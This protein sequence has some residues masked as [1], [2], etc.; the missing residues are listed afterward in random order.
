MKRLS[1]PSAPILFGLL[2]LACASA[3]G[4]IWISEILFNPPGSDAPNE[5]IELR[6][7]PNLVL[8]A[9]TYFV[10]V[11]GDTAKNPGTIKNVFDL[12]GRSIGGNGFLVLLQ[13]NSLYL[14]NSNATLLTNSGSG[15]GWGSGSGSSI[16]HKGDGGIT[17]L[18]HASVT[19]FLLQ[20]TN[21][22]VPGN[23]IDA[24]NDGVPDGAQFASWTIL[25]SVG[26]LGI[27]GAGDFAYGQINFR[28][29]PAAGATNTVP[30]TF[31]PGYVARSG[32]TTNWTAADWV[33]SD[34]TGTAPNFALGLASTQPSNLG[35]VGLTNIGAPNFGAPAIPGLVAGSS[36]G[37]TDVSESGATDTY[38]VLLNTMPT[39]N[40]T[41]QI[42]AD[43]QLQIST[44]AGASFSSSAM[45]TFANTTPRQVTVRALDDTTVDTSPHPAFIHHIITSSAD[46]AHY[47]VTAPPATLRVNIAEND[48]ALLNELKVNPPG[49]TDSPFEYMEIQGLPGALLTNVFFLAI[50]GNQE[51]NPGNV[52]LA[53]DL[54]GAHFGS[55]G[56]LV[57][58]ATNSPYTLPAGAGVFTDARFNAPG[59]AL[60]NGAVSFLLVSSPVPFKEGKDLDSGN[61]G[62]L[63]GLPDGATIL[64]AVG[65]SKGGSNDVVYG[66]AVL[67]LALPTPDAASRFPGNTSPRSAAAWFYGDL[68]GTN[69]ATLLYDSTQVSTN[70][71]FGALLTPGAVN[72]ITIG[73]SSITPFSG[74]IG[75]P[76]N[77]GAT[78]TVFDSSIYSN[79]LVVT[80]SSSNPSVVPDANLSVTTIGPGGLRLLTVNPVG[81]GYAAIIITANDGHNLAQLAFPYAASEMGRPG[82][83]FHTWASDGSTALAVDPDNMFVGD[84]ENQTLRLY[85]RHFS[86]PPLSEFDFAFEL[87][88]TGQEAGEVDI[89]ASTRVGNRLF[90]MG[91]QS[92]NNAGSGRTN[93]SRIFA[94]DLSPA[95]PASTLSYVGRYDHIKED[96]LNW[97]ANNL[98]GKGSNYYGFV[99]SAADG[100][101]PKA[102]DGFNIEG[103]TMAP[104]SSNIAWIGFRA[105]LVPPSE[106]A[107][108]LIVTVTNFD[109]LAIGDAPAG[110]ARF[111]PPIELNL[112]CRGIRSIESTSNAVLISAGPPGKATGASPDFRL[113]TWTGNPADLPQER[114]A[115]LTGLTPEGLVEVPPTPWNASSQVQ[116]ISDNGTTIYYGDDI[117]A[118]HLPYPGFKKF[119]S[120]FVALGDIAVSRPACARFIISDSTAFLSWC[121]VPLLTYRVQCKT[122]LQDI[123]WA[124]V[125]GLVTANGA[126]T[127]KPLP[128]EPGPQRFYRVIIPP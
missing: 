96:L 4:E 3:R 26:V 8:P 49:P 61:N 19:F 44:N 21:V 25:D 97:D 53:I 48:S 116:L 86:G 27:N 14:V 70:F 126:L 123:A 117:E 31:T 50:E 1:L 59:G 2:W 115:D 91:S 35:G 65:W 7:T 99:A 93:R 56:L 42:T 111:G 109:T 120:D 76:T 73:I 83:R 100:V 102:P 81:V 24:N 54:S 34:I 47:P 6:G 128:F 45:L 41:V 104:G 57:L 106:R 12:S 38:S 32:N 39:G 119:R 80:A 33:A 22:P 127:T 113:F 29:N 66:G 94:T 67:T 52:N 60:G 23:D 90:W 28:R 125:P 55:N 10:A 62:V 51:N 37:S 43:P 114:A 95:G 122:N 72:A 46:P 101:N 78:F 110:S 63:E 18:E 75:D 82:G 112:R 92:N 89:E 9:G 88:L 85:S 58:T 98:H 74:V 87:N 79:A 107:S 77:P 69:A 40:V 121:S 64:D 36:G 15:T 105:P 30:V 68:Q 16:G 84:D 11:E 5:Y 13:K 71:P 17:D 103:L 118:K 124:D 20:S 108:A